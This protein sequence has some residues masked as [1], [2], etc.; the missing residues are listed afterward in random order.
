MQRFT[1]IRVCFAA[2]FDLLDLTDVRYKLFTIVDFEDVVRDISLGSIFDFFK[3][4]NVF[5]LL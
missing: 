1:S 5:T 3:E 2:L 4:I